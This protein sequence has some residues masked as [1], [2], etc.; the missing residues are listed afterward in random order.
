MFHKFK[1][2]GYAPGLAFEL[3]LCTAVNWALGRVLT[4]LLLLG[5]LQRLL[6]LR[7]HL[8]YHLLSH[9]C[10]TFAYAYDMRNACMIY[11]LTTNQY[12]KIISTIHTNYPRL[13]PSQPQPHRSDRFA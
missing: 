2:L 8:V 9:G 10:Y 4:P 3:L 5:L 1:I 13:N 6:W 11:K 7:K 12:P